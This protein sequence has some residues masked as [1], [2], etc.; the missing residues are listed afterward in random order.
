M[1]CA[2]VAM[3]IMT[4]EKPRGPTAPGSWTPG[5]LRVLEA[6]ARDTGWEWTSQ[7]APRILEEARM[8]DGD[9]EEVR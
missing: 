7:H 2:V 3:I 6:V 4:T 9:L 5:E 8:I 1:G